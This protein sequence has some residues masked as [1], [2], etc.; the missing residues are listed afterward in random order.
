[1]TKIG[2]FLVGLG[3]WL[4]QR[5]RQPFGTVPPFAALGRAAIAKLND[6][7]QQAE[8]ARRHAKPSTRKRVA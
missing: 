6:V 5:P 2:T 1:M 3:L 7:W 8:L 4:S